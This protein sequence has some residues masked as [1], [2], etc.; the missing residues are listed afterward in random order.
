MVRG[1]DEEKKKKRKRRGKR[2]RRGRLNGNLTAPRRVIHI[3]IQAEMPIGDA[4]RSAVPPAGIQ[5]HN[6]FYYTAILI[7][8]T[9]DT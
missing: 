3:A 8:F 6:Q 9:G 1:E 7:M 2:N 5:L 4:S